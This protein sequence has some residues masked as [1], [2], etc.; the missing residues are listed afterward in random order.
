MTDVRNFG[1]GLSTF[2]STSFDPE[3]RVEGQ[4]VLGVLGEAFGGG[5]GFSEQSRQGLMIRQNAQFQQSKIEGFLANDARFHNPANRRALTAPASAPAALNDPVVVNTMTAAQQQYEQMLALVEFADSSGQ[6]R[7]GSVENARGGILMANIGAGNF[8]IVITPQDA[9]ILGIDPETGA[10]ITARG[11]AGLENAGMD[12]QSNYRVDS[13]GNLRL[14]TAI[15]ST[16]GLG[17]GYY[18][19]GYLPYGYGGGGGGGRGSG[20][21]GRGAYNSYRWRISIG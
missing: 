8:P 6:E 17:G 5:R 2:G 13:E 11:V 20:S 9:A 10:P 18:S 7:F 15:Q 4:G 14:T 16:N 21:S 12:F 3:P 19:S 1:Q